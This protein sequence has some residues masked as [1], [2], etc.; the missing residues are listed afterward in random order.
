MNED[1]TNKPAA[2]TSQ[3]GGAA[4]KQAS[5]GSATGA[6]QTACKCTSCA[7]YSAATASGG[8]KKTK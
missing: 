2:S 8:E 6:A 1:A 3:Q 5:G 7:N 4:D